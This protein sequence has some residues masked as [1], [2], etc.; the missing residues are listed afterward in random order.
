[1]DAK[2]RVPFQQVTLVMKANSFQW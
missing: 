1:M 2:I